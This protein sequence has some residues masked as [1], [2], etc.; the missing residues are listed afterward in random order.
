MI[1]QLLNNERHSKSKTN[2]RMARLTEVARYFP[3][4]NETLRL[5][6][7]AVPELNNWSMIDQRMPNLASLK[8]FM[9]R[10]QKMGRAL[11]RKNSDKVFDM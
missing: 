8:T 1:W 9:E 2:C 6:A 3:R 4:L 7:L 10:Q 5:A 11:R